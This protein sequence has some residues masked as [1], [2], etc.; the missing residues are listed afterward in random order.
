MKRCWFV[1]N[2]QTIEVH[3]SVGVDFGACA[4]GRPFGVSRLLCDLARRLLME[5]SWGM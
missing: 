1:L 4:Y 5:V 2:Q 3:F